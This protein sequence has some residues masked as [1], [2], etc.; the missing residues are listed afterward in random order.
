ML[1]KCQE[2]GKSGGKLLDLNGLQVAKKRREII[3]FNTCIHVYKRFVVFKNKKNVN[4][5]GLYRQQRNSIRCTRLYNDIYQLCEWIGR[6]LGVR[7]IYCDLIS[8]GK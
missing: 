6:L 8:V 4:T 2:T 5:R 7:V 1:K 3:N